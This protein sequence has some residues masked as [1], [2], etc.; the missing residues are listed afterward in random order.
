[1]AFR[2]KSSSTAGD[3][4][5]KFCDKTKEDDNK[6]RFL[7]NG[8]RLDDESILHLLNLEKGDKIEVFL[9][10]RGGGPPKIKYLLNSKEDQILDALNE[11]LECSECRKV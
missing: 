10:C 4:K 7:L 9:E 1:M 3:L 11:S 5:E 8:E 2:M 6:T